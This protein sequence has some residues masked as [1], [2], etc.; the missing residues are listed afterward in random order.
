MRREADRS[1]LVFF[2]VLLLAV[3]SYT[4]AAT[5]AAAPYVVLLDVSGSM[6]RDGAVRY[7]RYSSGQVSGIARQLAHAIAAA[8]NHAV[9]YVQPFSSS[10]EQYPGQGPLSADQVEGAVPTTATG[11]E[12]EL[13]AG[14]NLGLRAGAD[15]YIFILT[16]N[17]NDFSGNRNDRQFYELLA[18][19]PALHTVYFVP[20]A[21]PNGNDALVLYAIACGAAH[22]SVLR[23]VVVDFARAVESEP[24]QFR[25]FYD[26][27]EQ[28]SLIL[29][30]QVLQSDESGEESPVSTEGDSIVLTYD[31][32][33]PVQ[34]ALKF[35]IRSKL[36]DWR[37]VDGRLGKLDAR[38]EVPGEFNS[39]GEYSLPISASAGR[40]INVAP[41]GDSAEVYT[42]PLSRISDAGVSLSRSSLF[43]THLPDIPGR[44]HLSVIVSVSQKPSESSMRPEFNKAMQQRIGTVRNL[45]EIMNLMTFQ[46]DRAGSS[47][48]TQRAIPINR[49]VLIRVSP[50]PLKNLLAHMIEFGLPTLLLAAAAVFLLMSRGKLYTLLEPGQRPR[51]VRLSRIN[52][53]ALLFWDG[54]RAGSIHLVGNGFLIRPDVGYSIDHAAIAGAPCQFTIKKTKSGDSRI[55]QM[56]SGAA[57][58]AG[59][60]R[61]GFL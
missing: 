44:I 48:E 39:A 16:D 51:T 19:S 36:N 10:H 50:N 49:A 2:P 21:Q 9:I 56:R 31:E 34:G 57:D 60:T 40:K 24:V 6:E 12:T 25:G 26:E 5:P 29:E 22:R 32:G 52:R 1:R 35:R 61:K 17:K 3:A 33:H 41:D 14:L 23:R 46:P 37:I 47:N 45:P 27:R 43:S 38:L 30:P 58:Q 55:Y 8:D 20:L 59:T 54:R 18:K 42:L 13:D 11:R 4:F 28:E 7:A 15:S 53:K